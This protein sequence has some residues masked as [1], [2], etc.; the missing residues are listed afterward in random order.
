MHMMRRV[1]RVVYCKYKRY[2]F[3]YPILFMLRRF[4]FALTVVFLAHRPFA[5]IIIY[6]LCSLAMLCH[7]ARD[8]PFNDSMYNTAQLGNEFLIF[9][10]GFLLYGMTSVNP[11]LEVRGALSYWYFALLVLCVVINT[12]YVIREAY[13]NLKFFLWEYCRQTY[14]ISV[15][16]ASSEAD[17]FS[18]PV[19]NY[20]Q[21]SM[22]SI[23]D[24]NRLVE[25]LKLGFRQ[26]PEEK[27]SWQLLIGA[28]PPSLATIPKIP[29]DG[30]GI[31]SENTSTT[32]NLAMILKQAMEERKKMDS[33]I[34]SQPLSQDSISQPFYPLND[35]ADAP[36]VKERMPKLEDFLA[37]AVEE[38][39]PP[40][41]KSQT[42]SRKL[43]TQN[44]MKMLFTKILGDA[45]N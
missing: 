20:S 22:T 25:N 30:K 42:I 35:K 2:A 14:K 24:N 44:S 5:Q 21:R 16:R 6:E 17:L 37:R 8:K 39:P 18:K 23:L 32:L 43:S 27:T 29:V 36:P 45:A 3:T 11:D 12:I 28:P 40:I 7:I 34:N 9:L 31:K 15:R 41:H 1:W 26:E 4:I 10:S 33:N 13:K 19:R 38:T